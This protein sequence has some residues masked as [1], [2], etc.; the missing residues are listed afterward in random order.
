[1]TK[2]AC[3]RNTEIVLHPTTLSFVYINK[4]IYIVCSVSFLINIVNSENI[5]YIYIYIC[6]EQNMVLV[7]V[8]RVDSDK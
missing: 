5:V 8:P 2:A 7:L 1:M 4:Y 6:G 3:F